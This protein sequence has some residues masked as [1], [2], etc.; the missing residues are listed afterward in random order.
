MVEAIF[1]S[2]R[3]MIVEDEFLIAMEIED[4]LRAAG[5]EIIGPFTSL[6]EA[7]AAARTREIDLAILD[8]DLRGQEVFPAA[9]VLLERGIPFMFYTGRP[10]RE[11]LRSTFA[12]VPVCV[13]PVATRR[14]IGELGKLVPLAA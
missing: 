2:M 7:D 4:A 9:K 13:K 11:A 14:L 5:A 1:M 6:E 12:A 3:V 8:I 10:D